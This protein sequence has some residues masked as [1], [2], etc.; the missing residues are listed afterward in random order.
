MSELL[1]NNEAVAI[2]EIWSEAEF[3]HR[4]FDENFYVFALSVPRLSDNSDIINIMISDKLYNPQS[5]TIGD[6]FEIKGQFRSYN[7]Y[8]GNGNKLKLVLFAKEI[9]ERDKEILFSDIKPNS[10]YL[11]G[12]LCKE[13][14]YR[15]TPF[16][17]EITDLLVAVNRAYGKSDYIPCIAWGR[18]AKY[19]SKLRVGEHV[20]IWGRMQSRDYSKRLE[21]DEIV[22]KKAFEVSISRIN[23]IEDIL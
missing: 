23:V 4:H 18:N 8:S 11:S 16:G 5:I 14:V 7:N 6:V 19:T 22:M 21:N 1:G 9:I 12:Y 10:L 13:P 2:G 3:S 20:E 17:R 15:T